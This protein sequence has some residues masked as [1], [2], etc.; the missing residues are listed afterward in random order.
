M[1]PDDLLRALKQIAEQYGSKPPSLKV[2]CDAL[3]KFEG[4]SFEEFLKQGIKKSANKK[5]ATKKEV[6]PSTADPELISD[7]SERILSFSG[8]VEEFSL[9]LQPL[10]KSDPQTVVDIHNKI[11][12]KTTKSISRPKAVEAI[13]QW[14][15][16][17]S[18]IAEHE[19]IAK[20]QFS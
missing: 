15:S 2:L 10:L 5:A 13:G 20:R 17:R 19:R 12:G 14:Y 7:W 18:I 8:D 16:S 6:T 4:D 11:L 3:E 9:V 1:T